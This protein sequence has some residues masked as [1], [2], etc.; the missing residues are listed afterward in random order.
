MKI[1]RKLWAIAVHPAM[2]HLIFWTWNSLFL[3]VAIFGL[4]PFLLI[5]MFRDAREGI[6]PW[7][8]VATVTGMIA[9]PF[10][11]T[12]VGAFALRRKPG[13]LLRFFFGVE[14][15]AFMLALGRVFLVRELN[16]GVIFVLFIFALGGAAMAISIFSAKKRPILDLIL[17]TAAFAAGVYA[18][19]LIAFYA[20]PAAGYTLAW[21]FRFETWRDF[22]TLPVRSV[23][24][25]LVGGLFVAS[26]AYF[27]AMPVALITLFVGRFVETARVFSARYG[28]SKTALIFTAALVAITAGFFLSNRQPHLNAFALLDKD[29][30]TD[31]ERRA[32][33]E[34]SDAIR[35]GLLNAYLAKHRYTAATGGAT[36]VR[37]M[38]EGLFGLSRESA[39][40][41]QNFYEAWMGPWV[42]RGK[43]EDRAKAA[44]LY[45]RFFDGNIQRR[46]KASILRAIETTWDRSSREA[47]LLDEGD[48]KVHVVRQ[49][50]NVV[51]HGDHAAVEIHE[52]YENETHDQQEVFYAFSLP[53]SAVLTGLYLGDTAERDRRFPF[54]VAPRGAAQSVY[55]AEVQR[56][57]DPALL[58]Q[59]G[60]RQYRLRAFPVPPKGV[61][62]MWMS[63]EVLIDDGAIPL[64]QLAEQRNVYLDHRTERSVRAMPMAIED[65]TAWFPKSL[66][67]EH[68]TPPRAHV[69]ELAPHVVLRAAPIDLAG[70]KAKRYLRY[71]VVLDRS[72]SMEKHKEELAAAFEWLRAA[73]VRF[74]LYLTSAKSRGE[75][76][77]L[78][79]DASR[80]DP[81]ETLYF[82]GQQTREM[83]DQMKALAGDRT[84]AAILVL[85][86][87]GSYELATDATNS[88]RATTPAN[89]TNSARET[90]PA[91]ATNSAPANTSD[92]DRP[93]SAASLWIIHL[94]GTLPAAYDDALLDA[95]EETHGGVTSDLRRAFAT[96][97]YR[98]IRPH[99]VLED[100]YAWYVTE[101]LSPE[102]TSERSFASLAARQWIRTQ[103]KS[104]N[105]SELDRVHG[106]AKRFGIVTPYSSML[107]LV[108]DAQR[109]LLAEREQQAD[110]F[111]R[112][113]ETGE[114]SFSSPSGGF[115]SLTAT[116]EP[117]EWALF[118]VLIMVAIFLRREKKRTWRSFDA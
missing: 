32:L 72:R 62:H 96:I 15:P 27:A 3:S 8:L 100:G 41:V 50:L 24:G 116:P 97:A 25:L 67:A 88:A 78:I 107:V 80:F 106:I 105:A 46:E 12:A 63:Y 1:L 43:S 117:H 47:G 44:E 84:Y 45:A 36:H 26:L 17:G 73:E 91:N 114:E 40:A 34:Q 18:S 37:D 5:E 23:L 70:W 51:E 81:R 56:R 53:S 104:L 71:A 69:V 74:D 16:E 82:G 38:W 66:A 101:P 93:T 22:F 54:V 102:E 33:L 115:P 95:I 21:L 89:A 58:E 76:P 90:T 86:D 7:S 108:N 28:R 29:P 39:T 61:L 85:S 79:E 30:R 99:T 55:K 14:A 31:A 19:I 13:A 49:E 94:G 48:R 65:D 9:V 68:A 35:A 20:I 11:A 57:V 111:E 113:V 59:V 92:T 103:T 110:R 83:L 6:L 42:Y 52:L 64:P 77:L 75:E 60:P 87:E 112:E 2:A 4:I 10:V 118:T 109:Q 98:D